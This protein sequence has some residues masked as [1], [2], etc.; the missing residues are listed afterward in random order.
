MFPAQLSRKTF[1]FTIPYSIRRPENPLA[2]HAGLAAYYIALVGP[3]LSPDRLDLSKL[4]GLNEPISD[5][6]RARLGLPMAPK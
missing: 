1:S 4:L 6:L 3:G 2:R 5:C